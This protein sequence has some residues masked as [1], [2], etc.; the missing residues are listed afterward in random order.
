MW[1]SFCLDVAKGWRMWSRGEVCEVCSHAMC[2][3]RVCSN[4]SQLGQLA[5]SACA[6]PSTE[7]AGL[8]TCHCAALHV[9]T[10]STQPTV[11]HHGQP[12]HMPGPHGL[13]TLLSCP[14]VLLTPATPLSCWMQLV[15]GKD[16][17]FV[18]MGAGARSVVCLGS[19]HGSPVA[20]KVGVA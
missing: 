12:A 8:C 4:S 18:E 11:L 1:G 19:L 16:G 14:P 20:V 3:L 7:V 17:K 9:Q 13:H 5:C 15:I 2:R 10:I 6:G